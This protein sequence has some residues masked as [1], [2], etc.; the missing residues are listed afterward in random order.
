MAPSLKVYWAYDV[1]SKRNG[2]EQETTR[3]EIDRNGLTGG[4]KIQRRNQKNKGLV[5]ALE[6]ICK[7]KLSWTEMWLEKSN[8]LNLLS[9]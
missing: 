3:V 6:N 7:R 4:A 2:D 5:A 8:K 9:H 1:S